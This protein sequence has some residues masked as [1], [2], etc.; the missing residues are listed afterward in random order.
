ME[1]KMML[2]YI[3]LLSKSKV[4]LDKINPRADQLDKWSVRE[5][6]KFISDHD[7]DPK[8]PWFARER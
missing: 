5:V 1:P 7:V 3:L 8:V 6:F 4:L 2:T